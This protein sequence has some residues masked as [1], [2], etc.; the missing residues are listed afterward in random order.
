MSVDARCDEIEQ[1]YKSS[2]Y[3]GGSKWCEIID[4]EGRFSKSQ[5]HGRFFSEL[6]KFVCLAALPM[7]IVLL[8]CLCLMTDCSFDFFK[9]SFSYMRILLKYET[10]YE[11]IFC[12]YSFLFFSCFLLSNRTAP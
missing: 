10:M 1:R 9:I 4:I 5:S 2:V 8:F 12:L 7:F 6:D 3:V 11:I